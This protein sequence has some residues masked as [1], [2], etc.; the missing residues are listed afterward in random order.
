V[1]DDDPRQPVGKVVTT[2]QDPHRIRI[3]SRLFHGHVR[4]STLTMCVVWL[5]LWAAY[6]F[7]N[8]ADDPV[9]A[10]AEAVIISQTPY[11]PYVSPAPATEQSSP[12]TSTEVAPP[13]TSSTGPTAPTTA[14]DTPAPA[15]G[16]QPPS[17]TTPDANPFRLPQIPGLP[18]FEGESGTE[19]TD[20][21]GQ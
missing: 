8:Q 1:I 14:G 21:P 16:T 3:P 18:G 2:G 10:P 9:P 19:R 11:V 20:E 17:A 13:T 5:A 4:T 15:T 7:F 6:L 12:A